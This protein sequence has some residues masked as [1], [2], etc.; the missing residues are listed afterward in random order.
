MQPSTGTPA[1]AVTHSAIIATV[2][3]VLA[4]CASPPPPKRAP[5]PPPEPRSCGVEVSRHGEG[6]DA[7]ARACIWQAH[8]ERE[9]AR[10]TTTRYT[11]EGDPITYTITVTQSGIDVVVDSK[12]R[13]GQSGLFKH[14]CRNVEQ[15]MQDGNT[16][17]FGFSLSGCT[18]AG[19]DRL[20]V[21]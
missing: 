16:G 21:P 20:A 11:I 15:I 8:K 19:T 13:L 6:Y 5:P 4:A 12:D 17:R 7:A 3:V 10:F 2:A 1:P 14:T 9:F 18:G